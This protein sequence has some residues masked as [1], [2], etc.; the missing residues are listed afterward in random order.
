MPLRTSHAGLASA[1]VIVGSS[2]ISNVCGKPID[3][4][5]LDYWG[6]GLASI[7]TVWDYVQ[8]H[9]KEGAKPV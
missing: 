1:A 4:M 7:M 8:R 3:L 5:G 6:L 2:I 9:Y